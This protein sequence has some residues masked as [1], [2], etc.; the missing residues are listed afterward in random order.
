ML[1]RWDEAL[2]AFAEVPEERL[3]EGTTAGFLTSLPEIHVARGEID[4]AAH[5]VSLFVG[6]R[7]MRRTSSA[8][9][10]TSQGLP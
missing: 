5:V 2:A 4:R 7:E 6:L 3:F 1:G 9:C 10:T 8:G